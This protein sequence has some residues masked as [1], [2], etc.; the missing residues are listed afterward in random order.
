MRGASMMRWWFAPAPA[1][2]LAML[3]ILIGSFALV[4]V[5]LRLPELAAIARLPAANFA[6]VGVARVAV[7]PWLAIAIAVATCLLLGA[8]I[9]G[10]AYRVTAPLCAAALL[11]TLTYRSAWGQVFHVENVLVLHVIALA[12][13]PAADVWAVAQRPTPSAAGYGWSIKLLAALT[14][15]TYLLAGIAKLRL[16]GLAWIDG[17][18][19][20]DQVAV[21]NL[22]KALLGDG[23][24]WGAR[25]LID[26][27]AS[28]AVVSVLTLV[29]ELAAPV[30]L[31]GG[32]IGRIWACA[33]WVFHLGVFLTMN[34]VF[35]YALLGFAFLPWL[36]VERLR[37]VIRAARECPG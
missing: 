27:S 13:A 19:L 33:A 35:P 17:E 9:A 1:E 26:H 7:A 32:R 37:G 12:C 24:G 22:R 8:F 6:A 11:F 3:R 5:V 30:A 15:A 14:V 18:C 20:R 23:V 29:L 10:F 21:D 34:I 25:P 36:P 4:Y 28:C 16:G 2:R 31:L